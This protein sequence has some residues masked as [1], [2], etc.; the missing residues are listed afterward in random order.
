MSKTLEELR[1]DLARAVSMFFTGT[2]TANVGGVTKVVDTNGLPV[3]TEANALVGALA[4]I[5]T[6]ASGPGDPPQGEALRVV[7]SDGADDF[8]VVSP[9]FTSAVEVGDVYELYMNPLSLAEWNQAINQAILE[10]WPDVWA[11]ESTD[12]TTAATDRYPL[13]T[14]AEGV[15]EV[16]FRGLGPL[17]GYGAQPIPRGLW[18]LEG[19]PGTDLNLHLRNAVEGGH[20][21]AIRYKAPYAELA[22]AEST[23]L[24]YS[25]LMLSGQAHLY[26]MLQGESGAGAES[27]RYLQLM[28]YFR[29]EAKERKRALNAA[30]LGVDLSVPETRTK[31]R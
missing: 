3:F 31:G 9:G 18:R 21:L 12:L 2:A 10:A 5:L 13:P 1:A 30:L 25:Y 28:D 22:A 29:K 20:E 23:D 6:D 19:T 15:L 24:D 11:I 16:N 7:A 27:E 4:Y 14:D 26:G 8:T 17:A